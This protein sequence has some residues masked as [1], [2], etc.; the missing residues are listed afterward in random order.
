M[1]MPDLFYIIEKWWKKILL[2]AIAATTLVVILLFL[3]PRLYLSEATALRASSYTT[4]KASIFNRNIE[5][6]YSTLGSADDLDMII[7]TAQLDTVYLYQVDSFEL[8][9][10][11]SIDGK[12]DL[13]RRKASVRLQKNSKVMK[14]GYGEL[15]VKVWDKDKV[16]A[17]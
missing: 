5:A 14:S 11:Y 15:K 4:D 3:Q 2:F 17:A 12:P 8:I 7:G 1:D 16:L 9:K 13:A 10:H 6:L